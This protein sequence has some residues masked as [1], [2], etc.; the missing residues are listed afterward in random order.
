MRP[1]GTFG[2]SIGR[3]LVVFDRTI[4]A[5]RRVGRSIACADG[6]RRVTRTA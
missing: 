6:F 5:T 3:A 2:S 4:V 1:Y